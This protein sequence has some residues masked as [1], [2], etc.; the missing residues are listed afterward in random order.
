MV[1]ILCSSALIS[2]TFDYGFHD[3]CVLLLSPYVC[4]MWPHYFHLWHLR[5]LS[6]DFYSPGMDPLTQKS[7]ILTC[8]GEMEVEALMTTSPLAKTLREVKQ[9]LEASQ[10]PPCCLPF[11]GDEADLY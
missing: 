5:L 7:N 11:S 3:G 9:A 10:Q 4:I 1:G 6:P 2:I 8:L